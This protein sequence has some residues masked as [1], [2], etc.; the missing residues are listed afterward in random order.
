MDGYTTFIAVLDVWNLISGT[1]FYAWHSRSRMTSLPRLAETWGFSEGHVQ[2]GGKYRGEALR[3]IKTN[4]PLNAMS[5]VGLC[6]SVQTFS[7]CRNYQKQYIDNALQ[8]LRDL[9]SSIN[10]ELCLVKGTKLSKVE[11]HS[12]IMLKPTMEVALNHLGLLHRRWV[13]GLHKSVTV[14][15]CCV[16]KQKP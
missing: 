10:F 12:G 1:K 16:T 15:Q 13:G 6:M 9:C 8:L 5:I 14:C 2:R 4:F 7:S 11:C 3:G